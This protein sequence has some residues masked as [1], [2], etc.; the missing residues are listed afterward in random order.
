[1]FSKGIVHSYQRPGQPGVAV[2][3]SWSSCAVS[4]IFVADDGDRDKAVRG[5][6]GGKV[7]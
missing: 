5:S 1:M 7:C 2:S 6:R 4:G 3:G